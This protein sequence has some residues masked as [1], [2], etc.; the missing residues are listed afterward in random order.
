MVDLPPDA[1][2][3]ILASANLSQKETAM[4]A[5]VCPTLRTACCK[6]FQKQLT[7]TLT[8]AVQVKSMAA[9]L[10][11]HGHELQALDVTFAPSLQGQF[12]R[13][14]RPV[15]A[16]SMAPTRLQHRVR[17]PSS[18]LAHAARDLMSSFTSSSPD[19][20][21]QLRQLA[22]SLPRCCSAT[23]ALAEVASSLAAVSSFPHLTS[24]QFDQ[25]LA[26][27]ASQT[28]APIPEIPL[29]EFYQP[30]LQLKSLQQLKLRCID[31]PEQ[32]SQLSQLTSL[33]LQPYECSPA[34]RFW[35]QLL[36]LLPKLH[37][38]TLD[39]RHMSFQALPSMLFASQDHR[40]QQLK[41]LNAGSCSDAPNWFAKLTNLRALS[42]LEFD[43]CMGGTPSL[44]VMSQL[45]ELS[46]RVSRLYPISD[47]E[48]LCG[49]AG[50]GWMLE[51]EVRSGHQ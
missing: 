31:L 6:V 49:G 7:V 38:L 40:L 35:P 36:L 19:Q 34:E 41:L 2:Q 25:D 17:P 23:E 21:L 29:L 16:M 24:L 22:V 9:W 39:L 12:V 5:L 20:P 3:H 8:S 26:P 51:G 4:L 10:S 28:V 14:K 45:Q 11:R 18:P 33:Q 13:R 32:L 50:W 27:S 15:L 44:P 46:F 42:S 37:S 30:L 48:G 1:W 47:G 43:G